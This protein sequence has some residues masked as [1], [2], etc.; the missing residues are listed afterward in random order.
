MWREDKTPYHV[1]HAFC[2]FAKSHPGAKLHLYGV[3]RNK[4]VDVLLEQVKAR[5]WLGE[6]AGVVTGLENVYR[7]ATMAISPHRIA[8]RSIRESLACGCPVVHALGS[9]ARPMHCPPED[10]E[11]FAGEMAEL[12]KRDY[13][14][15]AR[16]AAEE[17]YDSAKTATEMMALVNEVLANGR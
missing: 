1:I 17:S 13:R 2:R 7:A 3:R 9:V 10:L 12:L 11:A 6:V 15:D 4:A 14:A 5:G 8:T 16:R